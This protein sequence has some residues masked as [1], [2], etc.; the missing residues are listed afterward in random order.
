MEV[1]NSKTTLILEKGQ[2][3][4]KL[5][6]IGVAS[7]TVPVTLASRESGCDLQK[8]KDSLKVKHTRN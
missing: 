6:V 7:S 1:R 8:L 4:L 2:E 5:P 3:N